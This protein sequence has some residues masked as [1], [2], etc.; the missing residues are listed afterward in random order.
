MI[1]LFRLSFLL[2]VLK[3]ST[4]TKVCLKGRYFFSSVVEVLPRSGCF[5]TCIGAH[6]PTVELDNVVWFSTI[7]RMLGFL[8]H[9]SKWAHQFGR[10]FQY[11]PG[12]EVLA[13]C[14]DTDLNY[15]TAMLQLCPSWNH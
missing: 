14:L 8:L 1:S 12:L 7:S 4:D 2:F 11:T 15:V 6:F 9:S 5:I 13:C 3:L 10:F